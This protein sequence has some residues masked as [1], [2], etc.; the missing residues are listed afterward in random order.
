MGAEIWR[1]KEVLEIVRVHAF[2]L[3]GYL[4]VA[5]QTPNTT[6]YGET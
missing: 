3:K 6:V 2:A 1:L 4:N 5:R